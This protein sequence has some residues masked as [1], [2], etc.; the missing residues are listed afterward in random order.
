MTTIS[1]IGFD[2]QTV[3][4]KNPCLTMWSAED[5]GK[6]QHLRHQY[7]WRIRGLVY[8]VGR[9]FGERIEDAEEELNN[10]L[11]D[12]EMRDVVDQVFLPVSRTC[13]MQ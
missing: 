7:C 4:Y 5:Q 2:V 8:V 10:M 1:T 11:I 13:S 9:R 12:D 3:E 6:I